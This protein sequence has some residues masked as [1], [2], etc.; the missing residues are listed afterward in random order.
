[1]YVSA[2]HYPM[3]QLHKMT[4]LYRDSTRPVVQCASSWLMRAC[5][6]DAW[7]CRSVTNCL[8]RRRA[9]RADSALRASRELREPPSAPGAEEDR[10]RRALGEALVSS[11]VSD[12][13]E[14][15]KV[16]FNHLCGCQTTTEAALCV[17][18]KF[19]ACFDRC[20]PLPALNR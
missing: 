14:V 5:R 6:P 10:R 17:F 19:R 18:E 20:F 13:R 2:L 12:W 1:M 7:S 4:M 9:W 8:C 15:R 11:L 16:H 3:R